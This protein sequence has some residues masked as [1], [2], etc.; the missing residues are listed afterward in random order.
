VIEL[1]AQESCPVF[2]KIRFL[3]FT[4][5]KFCQ[6]N[7]SVEVN[8]GHVCFY[9]DMFSK[10]KKRKKEQANGRKLKHL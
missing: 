5:G 4:F 3:C 2:S 1:F 6:F 8:T 7:D 9:G 10:K